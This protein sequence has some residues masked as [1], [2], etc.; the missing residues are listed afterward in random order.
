MCAICLQLQAVRTHKTL[1]WGLFSNDD[2]ISRIFTENQLSLPRE[3]K[4]C[5][6]F[7]CCCYFNNTCYVAHIYIYIYETGKFD[8]LFKY[9]AYLLWRSS[10]LL[11]MLL[12]FNRKYELTDYPPVGRS[13]S[14]FHW[15][16]PSL[17]ANRRTCIQV[18]YKCARLIINS[19]REHFRVRLDP[20]PLHPTDSHLG[21]H[22][23][24]CTAVRLAPL[25]TLQLQ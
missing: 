7:F 22:E 15:I 11:L 12:L 9:A 17:H 21:L 23:K 13:T 3:F 5:S 24:P 1:V 19:K 10:L 16:M 4:P 25:S 8:R 18:L 2:E 14:P 6:H 20:T